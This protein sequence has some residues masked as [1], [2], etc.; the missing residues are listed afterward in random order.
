MLVQSP[1]ASCLEK[2]VKGRLSDDD[3][4]RYGIVEAGL[5]EIQQAININQKTRIQLLPAKIKKHFKQ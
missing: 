5:S 4:V 1:I 3:D 2:K